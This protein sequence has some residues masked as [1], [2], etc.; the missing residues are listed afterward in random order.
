MSISVSIVTIMTARR[1]EW[2]IE[3]GFWLAISLSVYIMLDALLSE[4]IDYPS[5]LGQQLS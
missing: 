2:T 5:L 1:H 4:W 3:P